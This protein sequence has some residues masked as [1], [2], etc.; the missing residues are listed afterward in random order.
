MSVGPKSNRLALDKS[1]LNRQAPDRVVSAAR[2]VTDYT[3]RVIPP[4]RMQSRLF[5]G[6]C[7]NADRGARL[8][9]GSGAR[10]WPDGRLGLG[11]PCHTQT[12]CRCSDNAPSFGNAHGA[13]RPRSKV[14]LEKAVGE[15]NVEADEDRLVGAAHCLFGLCADAGSRRNCQASATAFRHVVIAAARSARWVWAETPRRR[16]DG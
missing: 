11:K 15:N 3:A 6:E 9:S 7:D 2:P 4:C 13:L 16:P 5:L 8:R 1:A 10:S 14:L 12:T